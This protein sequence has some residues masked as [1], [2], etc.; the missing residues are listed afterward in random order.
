MNVY[1]LLFRRSA[2]DYIACERVLMLVLPG[3]KI[4]KACFLWICCV[5][6]SLL[7]H[8]DVCNLSVDTTD[9]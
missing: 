6:S 1:F 4:M 5:V 3:S 8:A 9:Q 2:Y 7:N